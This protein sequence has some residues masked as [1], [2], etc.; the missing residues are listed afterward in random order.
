M[1]Y[2]RFTAAAMFVAA[3]FVLPLRAQQPT[4]PAAG[5]ATTPSR[6]ATTAGGAGTGMTAFGGATI[7]IIN[8]ELFNDQ[9]GGIAKLVT[10]VGGVD[11]EFQPRRT[12]LQTLQTNIQKA[13]DDLTKKAPVQDQRTTA[14]QQEQLDSLKRE[15]ERK[16]QDA[17]IAYNK[18]LGEV[19]G[20]LYED[21]GKNLEAFAKQ[22]GIGLVLDISKLGAAA[23]PTND[24]MDIT[25]AFIAEYNSRNPSTA[26]NA[27]PGR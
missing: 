3:F 26:S 24:S 22:R 20:P 25:G 27:A 2:R 14:T 12:E 13:T 21:I 8:T 1:N 19:L 16:Q 9:K 4:R 15:F 17:Q 7:A 5:G 11:R 18:R 23:F 10:A 6:P